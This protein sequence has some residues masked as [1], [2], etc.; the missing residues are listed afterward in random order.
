[1]FGRKWGT[2]TKQGAKQFINFL[3]GKAL[4]V[5]VLQDVVEFFISKEMEGRT[6]VHK[7]ERKHLG[8]QEF[9]CV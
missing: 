8:N 6:L 1:M 5:V 3:K 9:G 7:E 4:M 2:S